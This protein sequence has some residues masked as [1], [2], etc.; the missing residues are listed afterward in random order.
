MLKDLTLG[1]S[2]AAYSPAPFADEPI[3]P[4]IIGL[5]TAAAATIYIIFLVYF[6]WVAKE[7]HLTAWRQ[8]VWVAVH[9]P[10]HLALV[11]FMQGFTQFVIWAKIFNVIT[12]TT[13]DTLLLADTEAWASVTSIE[14]SANLSNITYKYFEQFPPTYVST[15]DSVAVALD[16]ITMVSDD[17]WPEVAAFNEVTSVDPVAVE[18]FRA[19]W[20]DD[21]NL[22]Y[23]SILVLQAGMN[24]AVF[25]AFGVDLAAEI[26]EEEPELSI[27]IDAGSFETRVGTETIQRYALVVSTLP[28]LQSII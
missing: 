9:F 25:E 2:H 4:L 26:F 16:N 13:V 6:D 22:M 17:F 18:D 15:W 3:D 20:T 8:Q 11:L 24:R 19:R 10:F 1:V 14:V 7:S 5:V 21:F 28:C 12:S 27:D 23:N